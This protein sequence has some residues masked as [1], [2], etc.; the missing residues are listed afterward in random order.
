MD[1]PIYLL[2][3]VGAGIYALILIYAL[4]RGIMITIASQ[5]RE[6]AISVTMLFV[7][8][9]YLVEEFPYIIAIATV[10]A[11]IVYYKQL[12]VQA[13]GYAKMQSKE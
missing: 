12:G 8:S 4:V 1:S 3:N 11:W 5:L 13:L 7:G 2:I 10:L 9:W 6:A